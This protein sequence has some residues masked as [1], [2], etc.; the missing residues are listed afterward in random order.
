MRVSLFVLLIALQLPSFGQIDLLP[1]IDQWR[2][3]QQ[4]HEQHTSIVLGEEMLQTVRQEDSL[5]ETKGARVSLELHPRLEGGYSSGTGGANY[6]SSLGLLTQFKTEKRWRLSFAPI[7]STGSFPKYMTDEINANRIHPYGGIA[8]Y[9]A[10]QNHYN[11]FFLKGNV[12]FRA[13]NRFQFSFGN[14][15]TFLGDGYRSLMLSEY[16]NNFLN[17]KLKAKVWKFKYLFMVSQLRDFS[18]R[19]QTNYWDLEDK[20]TATHYMSWNITGKINLSFFESIVWRGQDTLLARGIEPNYLNPVIFFRPVE[21]SLG[22]T[23]NSILGLNFS[24][25]LKDGIKLYHQ[26]VLDEFLLSEIRARNGWWANKYAFQFGAKWER[27]FGIENLR[28]LGEFNSIRPF[29]FSHKSSQ[30]SYSHMNRPLGHPLG[31]NFNEG[32]AELLYYTDVWDFNLRFFSA[33]IGL[34]T[35][36]VSNGQNVLLS[37]ERRNGTYGH[38]IGQGLKTNIN[39]FQ[40]SISYL[41]WPSMGVKANLMVGYRLAKNAVL[42]EDDFYFRIGIGTNLN[43]VN[44]FY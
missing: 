12:E 31:A 41:L 1:R 42:E 3:I 22:S 30:E 18:D 37:Y 21:Y 27:A 16:S 25:E 39:H 28:V 14:T 2:S 6:E 7:I 33:G 11:S 17:F 19:S 36:A 43:R 32:L 5:A 40:T 23:D 10:G 9:S 8:I 13:S 29:T 20:Y 44:R 4:T 15:Q 24:W 34:D 38:K 35:G 26:L